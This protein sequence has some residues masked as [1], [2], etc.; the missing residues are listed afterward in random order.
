MS[1]PEVMTQKTFIGICI[2]CFI[3]WVIGWT[4]VI[5]MPADLKRSGLILAMFFHAMIF[6]IWPIVTLYDIGIRKEQ[7]KLVIQS[8]KPKREEDV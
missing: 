1:Q 8:S 4:L 6:I 3:S 5:C 7:G 2:A